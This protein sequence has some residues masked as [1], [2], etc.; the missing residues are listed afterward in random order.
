PDGAEAC[1]TTGFKKEPYRLPTF[2]VLLNGPQRAPL[3]APFSVS[4]LARWF[5]GGLLSDRPVTWRV[6][7]FPYAW[8]PPGRE[9]FA[10]S[11]DSRYAP[12]TPFRATPVLNRT[13]TTDA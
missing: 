9:G 5:A 2:E 4:L 10:F 8:T 13:A 6:T 3:D 12:D 11:S 1:G 7:Q